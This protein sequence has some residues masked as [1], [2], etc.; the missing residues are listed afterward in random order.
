MSLAA[1]GAFLGRQPLKLAVGDYHRGKRY[2]R[3]VWAERLVLGYGAI[4]LLAIGMAS[5][6]A[7]FPFWPPIILAVPFA[8]VQLFFD[9]RKQSRA[10]LAEL[11]GATAISALAA[12]NCNGS[13]LDIVVGACALV[14]TFVAGSHCYV[15]VR[16]RLRLAR[17]EPVYC[18]PALLLHLAALVIVADLLSLDWVGWPVLL[19]FA[20]L[21]LRCWIGLLPRSLATPTPLVGVQ[22]GLSLCWWWES[23]LDCHDNTLCLVYPP[24]RL[25]RDTCRCPPFGCR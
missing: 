11:A 24:S 16:I 25:C 23:G 17:N 19:V 9:L 8:V 14:V 21:F 7:A 1:L 22:E 6:Y 2:P 13:R 4:T 5:W 18:A 12:M 3:T 20:F 15:Y 10:L